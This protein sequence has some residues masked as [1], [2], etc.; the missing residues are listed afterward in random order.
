MTRRLSAVLALT[1]ALT[2]TFAAPAAAAPPFPDQID[3]P[4]GW[5]P[6]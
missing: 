3:L 1:L 4:N 2:A 5:A 6:E